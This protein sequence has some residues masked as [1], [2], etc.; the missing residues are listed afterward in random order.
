VLWLD[1]YN[2]LHN[3]S[4]GIIT[5]S[6][7]VLSKYNGI[8]CIWRTFI[9][10]SNLNKYTFCSAIVQFCCSI[11]N[12]QTHLNLSL[13][14]FWFC[15]LMTH[16]GYKYEYTHNTFLKSHVRWWHNLEIENRTITMTEVN[17][18]LYVFCIPVYSFPNSNLSIFY[19][20]HLLPNAIYFSLSL[21]QLCSC[22][23]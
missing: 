13:I 2:T 1:K 9:V 8:V 4:S 7:A 5:L 10:H 17:F 16:Y 19:Q 3:G 21:N 23:P 20:Q 18:E 12:F 11:T 14:W 22:F 15:L 6:T